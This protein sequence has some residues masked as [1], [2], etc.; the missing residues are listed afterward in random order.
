MYWKYKILD[1]ITVAQTCKFPRKFLWSQLVL[2]LTF[3]PKLLFK[4]FSDCQLHIPY[5]QKYEHQPVSTIHCG[6]LNQ[7]KCSK[8]GNSILSKTKRLVIGQKMV[9]PRLGYS[10]SP[11]FRWWS[12]NGLLGRALS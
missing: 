12:N 9:F 7:S 8:I 3:L 2:C 10:L 5:F 11:F 1:E 6:R 4:Y